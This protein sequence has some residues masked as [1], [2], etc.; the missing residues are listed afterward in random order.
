M[1]GM[2]GDD[3]KTLE[4]LDGRDIPK[5]E[6]DSFL[7]GTCHHLRR[8]PLAKFTFHTPFT[9]GSVAHNPMLGTRCEGFR[10]A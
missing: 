2:K 7:N 4:Q 8:K 1:G 5:P 9:V 3:D 10:P 6:L